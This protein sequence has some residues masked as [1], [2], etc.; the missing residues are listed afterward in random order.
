M[1]GLT[2]PN[3]CKSFTIDEGREPSPVFT[4]PGYEWAPL[5]LTSGWR[6]FNPTLTA[7][8]RSPPYAV[9][10][11]KASTALW[12]GRGTSRSP[13]SHRR[14]TLGAPE[15][16]AWKTVTPQSV[17]AENRLHPGYVG[18]G[19]DCRP[20]SLRLRVHTRFREQAVL[21]CKSVGAT[22]VSYVMACVM[23]RTIG[24]LDNLDERRL[25]DNTTVNNQCD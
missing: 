12:A 2:S 9:A 7:Q 15:V 13:R 4:T 3:G 25:D 21:L 6:I 14:C 19:D 10:G 23:A 5:V 8:G 24:R 17:H 18:I 11:G 1:G 20:L 22:H 16:T